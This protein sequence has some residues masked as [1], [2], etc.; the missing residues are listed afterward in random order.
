MF[1]NYTEWISEYASA[2]VFCGTITNAV[3]PEGA[4]PLYQEPVCKF[5]AYF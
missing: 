1:F 2:V 5:A 3:F 4:V